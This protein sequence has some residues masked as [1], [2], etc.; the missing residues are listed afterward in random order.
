MLSKLLDENKSKTIAITYHSSDR[1]DELFHKDAKGRNDFYPDCTYKPSSPMNGKIPP[2]A[3]DGDQYPYWTK[4]VDQAGID[5]L[6]S[7][8]EGAYSFEI[9]GEA[10]ASNPN[11]A[12]IYVQVTAKKNFVVR[13]QVLHVVAVEDNIDYKKRFGIEPK[14][15]QKIHHHVMQKMLPNHEGTI[16]PLGVGETGV[17]TFDYDISN[18]KIKKENVRIVAFVQSFGSQEVHDV[19]ISK[20]HPFQLSNST[21]NKSPLVGLN[22][23]MKLQKGKLLITNVSSPSNYGITLFNAHGRTLMNMNNVQLSEGVNSFS[24]PLVNGVTFVKLIDRLSN[25]T[26]IKKISF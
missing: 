23:S 13:D 25:Q 24:I 22:L 20:E 26:A 15:G 1:D 7:D 14:N 10:S 6:Y 16:L 2:S 12:K 18:T 19:D 9:K 21:K 17:F 5:K 4:W 11:K 3:P 8:T